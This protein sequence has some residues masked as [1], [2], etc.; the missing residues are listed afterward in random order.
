MS[1]GLL[2]AV[3]VLVLIVFLVVARTVRVIPQSRVAI[4]QRLGRYHRTAESGLTFIVP[5]IDQMLPKTERSPAART[6]S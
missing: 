2:V 6:W 5:V 3:V 1:I 4:V